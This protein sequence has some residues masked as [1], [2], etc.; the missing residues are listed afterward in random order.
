[1]HRCCLAAALA[2]IVVFFTSA[3]QLSAAPGDPVPAADDW[4]VKGALVALDSGD[5]ELMPR[6]VRLLADLNVTSLFDRIVAD[7]EELLASDASKG[8]DAEEL[9][10][11]VAYAL[12]K[13]L[14]RS[15]ISIPML[16][17]FAS[18]TGYSG[19]SEACRA[20][21]PW[22][23]ASDID[24]AAMAALRA[25]PPGQD[26]VDWY[27]CVGIWDAA[28]IDFLGKLPAGSPQAQKL[29]VKI[30]FN[31]EVEK[32]LATL[33]TST[34]EDLLRVRK[35]MEPQARK[36]V[37]E[38]LAQ[39]RR[40]GDAPEQI[41][42][43]FALL[44]QTTIVEISAR[45]DAATAAKLRPALLEH[46]E[47]ELLEV[48]AARSEPDEKLGYTLL[49]VGPFGRAEALRLIERTHGRPRLGDDEIGFL[50]FWAIALSGGDPAVTSATRWLSRTS[51]SPPMAP[52]KQQKILVEQLKQVLEAAAPPPHDIKI[53]SGAPPQLETSAI[54]LLLRTLRDTR[55]TAA[56]REFLEGLR[57][58]LK[59]PQYEEVRQQIQQILD[60]LEANAS[61][62]LAQRIATWAL[63]TFGLHFLIWLGLLVTI[64]PRSRTVQAL[65][66]FNPLGRAV[67][68]L[69]YTQLLVLISPWLRRRM[70]HP[71]VSASS[72]TEV[73]SFDA[74]SFY[75]R[76]QVAPLVPPK[77]PQAPVE[78]RPPITWTELQTRAGLIV[79]EGASGLG[80]THVLKAL[81]ERARA[82]G[83]TC[84]FLRA[85]ECNSGVLSEIEERLAIEH[86]SGFVRSMLHRGAIELFIDGLNEAS[87]SGVAAIAQ[88][89]ENARAARILITTQPLAW[90]CPRHAQQF[91][92]LPLEPGELEAF[93]S[94]QWPA[95]RTAMETATPEREAEAKAAY[96]ERARAFLTAS[97][98]P[99]DL[100][101]LQN[102]VDLAFVAHLLARA[103]TPNIHSL[104]KQVVDDAARAYEAASPG[105]RFP[106]AEL[107]AAALRVLETG[108]PAL[109]T[110]DL[111]PAVLPHLAERKLLLRRNDADW[112]FRHDTITCYFAAAG[113]FAPKILAS[114]EDDGSGTL[115]PLAVTKAHLENQRFT[116]VYLQL[117]E[118]LPLLAAEALGAALR[119]HGR[120]T[121]D[122]TL[123]IA[124]QDRVD[125]RAPGGSAKH[126]G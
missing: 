13:L 105:G 67:T 121:Q 11:A 29:M 28:G 114:I 58:A 75:D 2:L 18:R 60:A 66:L 68:G 115:D 23:F 104:R 126:H 4:R 76:I 83:R 24:S 71:L 81:L 51:A 74:A 20:F 47:A 89:C 111:D 45:L 87:P 15:E 41:D 12:G 37:D 9:R 63:A 43:Y 52:P 107:A 62:P 94:A 14:M 92:L 125:R 22:R 85:A 100:A 77:N 123:E 65:M 31:Q 108:R 119:E 10:D 82:E 102:R 33:D 8:H 84:L 120:V 27:T 3:A 103:E 118:A 1:M 55:W 117:A 97:T 124:Y 32:T 16:L 79:I 59:E 101:V 86:S 34:R 80:K 53:S 88:F 57:D 38:I 93:L 56:D 73:A 35:L 69:G 39:L 109:E 99:Q 49:A 48:P 116:G 122:R 54:E 70:F 96:L 19:I 7:G 5:P 26:A 95:V 21:E 64:Y 91:R 44:E 90:P 50:R 106:L 25:V 40:V 6:A 42:D 61:E 110:K 46:L 112:L 17:R 72:D 78:V 113:Y 36:P 30:V 98:S